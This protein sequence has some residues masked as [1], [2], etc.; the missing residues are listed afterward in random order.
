VEERVPAPAGHVSLPAATGGP[1]MERRAAINTISQL[2]PVAVRTGLGLALAVILAHHLNVAALGRYSLMIASV[3]LCNGIFNDWGLITIV[4][5]G[6]SSDVDGRPEMLS[7]A[8]ALQAVLSTASYLAL[9]A[10]VIVLGFGHDLALA[11]AIYGTALLLGPLTILSLPVNADLRMASFVGPSL[12]AAASNFC[13]VGAAVVLGAP[14]PWLAAATLLPM[15]LQF[16]LM[17]RLGVRTLDRLAMPS[18]REWPRFVRDSWPIGAATTLTVAWQQ[19]PVLLLGLASVHEAGIYAA[20]SRLVT[21][22]LAVPLAMAS[23][24]FPILS[25][26]WARDRAGFRSTIERSTSGSL[27]IV[28]PVALAVIA[29]TPT[30]VS[31][32]YGGAYAASSVPLQAMTASAALVFPIILLTQAMNSAGMQRST[33]I[34]LSV[35]TAAVLLLLLALA[36]SFGAAGAAI[37]LCAGYALYLLLVVIA[38]GQAG[39]VGSRMSAMFTTPLAAAT[40]GAA[41]LLV[42]SP[43]GPFVQAPGAALGALAVGYLLAPAMTRSSLVTTLTLGGLLRR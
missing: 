3:G 27:V 17:A 43:F 33:L 32:L 4:I 38:A 18:A 28:V 15:V 41:V 21:P 19:A 9:L 11:V 22:V 30:A 13:L 6:L 25:G 26:Q 8:A 39:L 20:A 35:S 12:V 7:S 40:A 29:L 36:P 5:R 10:G 2:P 24:A 31:I 14:L 23:T 16:A 42:L 37:A 34:V 1:G